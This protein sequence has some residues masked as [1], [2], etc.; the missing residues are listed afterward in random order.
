MT[1][2]Q[3][4]ENGRWQASVKNPITGKRQC[5]DFDRKVDAVAW[6]KR[7]NTAEVTG[8]AVRPRAGKITVGELATRWA[9]TRG[10]LKASSRYAEDSKVRTH[11]LPVFRDV[12]VSG[13]RRSDVASWLTAMTCAASTKRQAFFALSSILEL[14]VSDGEI[15]ANPALGV[16]LPVA[17]K[18]AK[19]R[20]G[21][22]EANALIGAAGDERDRLM[23]AVMIYTGLRFGE[24]IALR[25]GDL[26]P[27]R[28][29][30]TVSRSISEVG[31]ALELSAPKTHRNRVVGI[32]GVWAV[33]LAAF[34]VGRERHELIF[35]D[36]VGGVIR[37]SNWRRRVFDPAVAETIG[38]KMTPHGLRAVFVGLADDAGA[39]I[40][41][42]QH[43]MGHASP[44]MTLTRYMPKDAA[45]LDRLADDL[46][47]AATAEPACDKSATDGKLIML[48]KVSGGA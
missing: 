41:T 45:A 43:A 39:S 32:P 5:K 15:A 21:A 33:R 44:M 16:K 13:I 6:V 24:V 4:K 36:R 1:I 23:L 11:V 3:R 22:G 30:V 19:R 47:S 29:Q 14:A 8:T 7:M 46:D 26:D 20:L 28:R 34:V 25:V 18:P 35:T 9:G 37:L 12:P 17:A 40:T 38:G 27:L 31:A 2:R 48:P 42:V 10:H